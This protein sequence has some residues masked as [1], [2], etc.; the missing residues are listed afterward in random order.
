MR[1]IKELPYFSAT[2]FLLQARSRFWNVSGLNG[3]ARTDRPAEIWDCT[4]DVSAT[5]GVLGATAGGEAGRL[6]AEMG[7]E[8]CMAFGKDV[9][10]QAFPELPLNFEKG[11]AYRWSR[12]P[13]SRGAFAVF[14]PGQMSAFMPEVVR[15]EG[16]VHFAGEHTSSWMG[17]ME[18]ALESGERAARE[19]LSASGRV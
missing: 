4:Y 14:R 12:E 15:P 13:W 11:V 10:A 9:V 17:W 19:V 6:T 8:Q 5:R 2:R 3:S 1:V 16:R 18:G 7:D